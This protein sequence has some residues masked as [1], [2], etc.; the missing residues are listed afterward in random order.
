M[1]KKGAPVSAGGKTRSSTSTKPTA[2]PKKAAV[3]QQPRT[4]EMRLSALSREVEKELTELM[5]A[6][7]DGNTAVQ[8]RVTSD[9]IRLHRMIYEVVVDEDVPYQVYM[10]MVRNVVQVL[11][12]VLSRI[13][14]DADVNGLLSS[15]STKSSATNNKRSIK[16]PPSTSGGGPS[17]RRL[18]E[19]END[20]PVVSGGALTDPPPG[21]FS[22]MLRWSEE[23]TQFKPLRKYIVSIFQYLNQYVTK[24][25]RLLKVDRMCTCLFYAVVFEPSQQLQLKELERQW[26]RLLTE[27]LQHLVTEIDPKD[28]SM[29]DDSEPQTAEEVWDHARALMPTIFAKDRFVVLQQVFANWLSFL[30]EVDEDFPNTTQSVSYYSTE[31]GTAGS[32]SSGSSS[33]LPQV[34]Y[35]EL[36]RL[37]DFLSLP[38]EVQRQSK[39]PVISQATFHATTQQL[40]GVV[41]RTMNQFAT[42]LRSTFASG[43]ANRSLVVGGVEEEEETA[44]REVLIRTLLWETV[45]KL[46]GPLWRHPAASASIG[47]ALCP[48]DGVSMISNRHFSFRVLAFKW[49][50]VQRQ[51]AAAAGGACKSRSLATAGGDRLTARHKDPALRD[52]D[53]DEVTRVLQTMMCMM[54]HSSSHHRLL[55]QAA[56]VLCLMVTDDIGATLDGFVSQKRD[57]GRS[58]QAAAEASSQRSLALIESLTDLYYTYSSLIHRCLDD[59]YTIRAALDEAVK[60]SFGEDTSNARHQPSAS[61]ERQDSEET[62]YSPTLQV[63]LGRASSMIL[64]GKGR[65]VDMPKLLVEYF[66]Y[67]AVPEQSA[68]STASS[69]T[70]TTTAGAGAWEADAANRCD[71]VAL[72]VYLL[73]CSD[74]FGKHY[75]KRMMN[76]LMSMT[77]SASEEQLLLRRLV[78][79]GV[80]LGKSA[81]RTWETILYYLKAGESLSV[82]AKIPLTVKIFSRQHYHYSGW[83]ASGGGGSNNSGGGSMGN[84]A[85]LMPLEVQKELNRYV[86]KLSAAYPLRKLMWA[87]LR[88]AVEFSGKFPRCHSIKIVTSSLLQGALLYLISEAKAEGVCGSELAKKVNVSFTDL[89]PHLQVLLES[90]GSHHSDRDNSRALV[91]SVSPPVA[92]KSAVTNAALGKE[93][94]QLYYK[95]NKDFCRPDS[96]SP[97]A[98]LR[99]AAVSR[100]GLHLARG[101]D[102]A[103]MGNHS[104]SFTSG[105][106]EGMQA[107]VMSCLK[108][109]VRRTPAAMAGSV[110]PAPALTQKDQ[111]AAI[112]KAIKNKSALFSRIETAQVKRCLERLVE[113]GCVKR[114]E[115]GGGQELYV[116]TP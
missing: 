94:G 72:W 78:Y 109:E 75:K 53:V 58:H 8:Q 33:T 90:V 46:I 70:A 96:L 37:Q 115:G 9:W 4:A 49:V 106:I 66:C 55:L 31:S 87:H 83:G 93:E 89:F 85:W 111:V 2:Q 43:K 26:T 24:E 45:V 15:S 74:E 76:R 107:I 19:D 95:L 59:H 40:V 108:E 92:V 114:E 17:K 84:C 77:V 13:L 27:V 41:C 62:F 102:G 42:L 54:S 61:P 47:N 50:A 5:T 103:G 12:L 99:L 81:L 57:K 91:V 86:G 22:T 97:T 52:G 14:R 79:V 23:Y 56:G 3:V 30:R 73:K 18:D 44:W 112:V 100:G 60:N 36:T 21:S 20:L 51:Q 63:G 6:L 10:M 101:V 105:R 110:A 11:V 88:G 25:Y 82:S 65:Q 48:E 1:K 116:L 80:P 104:A 113:V 64:G 98:P 28:P 34:N 35:T 67:Y 38:P 16:S 29:D 69:S 32:S 7:H 68:T 71:A 39:M